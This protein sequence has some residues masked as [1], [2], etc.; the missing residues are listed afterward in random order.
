MPFRA[1]P[2][3]KKSM[4]SKKAKFIFITVLA[5]V[6]TLVAATQLRSGL[7]DRVQVLGW[8]FI[9]IFGCIFFVRGIFAI[10]KLK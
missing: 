3:K 8:G 6:L 4:T 10:N 2:P 9:M 1:A 7:T 5:F